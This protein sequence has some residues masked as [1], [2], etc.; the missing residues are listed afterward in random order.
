MHW[1]LAHGAEDVYTISDELNLSADWI[2][3]YED[4][5]REDEDDV[6]ADPVLLNIDSPN[7]TGSLRGWKV[8]RSFEMERPGEARVNLT[9]AFARCS[10][11]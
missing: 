5:K 6:D 10:L 7:I 11:P 9:P 2:E 8:H 1:N 4:M 3:V